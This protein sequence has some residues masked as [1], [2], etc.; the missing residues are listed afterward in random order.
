[1]SVLSALLLAGAA[2]TMPAMAATP[3]TP[4]AMG[5]GSLTYAWDTNAPQHYRAQMF[6]S[7]P[8]SIIQLISHQNNDARVIELT[9]AML[10]VCDTT[11]VQP[12]SVK[13]DCDVHRVEMGGVAVQGEQ[14]KMLDIFREYQDLLTA[15]T[16]Q[17]EFTPRGQLRTVDLEGVEKGNS[18]QARVHEYL[19]MLVSRTL[20]PMEVELPRDGDPKGKAWRQK[21]SPMAMRLPSV[22]G[23]AGGVRVLHNIEA[24]EN[25]EVIIRTS[26]QGTLNPGGT[27]TT[28]TVSVFLTGLAHY[29][30]ATGRL[31]SN[32]QTFQGVRTAQANSV[33]NGMY[34]NQITLLEAIPDFSEADRA[35]EEAKRKAAEEREKNKVVLEFDEGVKDKSADQL[36][37]S[38][39]D[40]MGMEAPE[41]EAA[42]EAPE[43]AEGAEGEEAPEA[44]E[45]EE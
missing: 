38:L 26:G 4:E 37:Q 14:K 13:V 29:D 15:A 20:A 31:V 41:E 39:R 42:P 7:M 25:G 11:D 23:T 40:V 36:N 2:L 33:G 28:N 5:P 24:I 35:A 32:E 30:L 16:I 1:M 12:K 17:L 21:G 9:L 19:R 44:P 22:Q 45:V 10:M 43:G 34:V 6:L 8:G 27:Q 3:T 18:R